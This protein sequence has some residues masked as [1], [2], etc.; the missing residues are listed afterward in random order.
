MHPSRRSYAV[1]VLAIAFVSTLAGQSGSQTALQAQIDRIFKDRAYDAPRFGP[2]RWQPDG[3]AYAIVEPVPDGGAEIARYDAA[4]GARA[5]LARTKL[6]VSDYAWSADGRQLL[7]FTNTR[8]V[9]RQRTR[10]DYYVIDVASAPPSLQSSA[11]TGAAKKLGGAAPEAS[12][13][14]AKFSPDATRVAYVRQN[15]IYVEHIASGVVTQLTKDGTTPPGGAA[16]APPTAGTVVN[17][18]SDWVNE[19]ELD[20]RDGFRWSPDGTHIA[21]WQFDTTGVGNMTLIDDTSALYPATTTFAYPKPGT[22]NSAVRV[23]VVPAGYADPAT[24]LTSEG[25]G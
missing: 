1:A 12:L 10:G 23:G 13:M 24:G 19:E 7:V 4:T 14:F 18:T 22:T 5:V 20:I 11:G 3:A 9:W 25:D 17:G 15:N 16:W 8:K 6:D 21:F 2:A